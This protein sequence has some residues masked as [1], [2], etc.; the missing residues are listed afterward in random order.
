MSVCVCVCLCVRGCICLCVPV[1]V[2]LCVC[3]CVLGCLSVCVSVRATVCVCLCVCACYGHWDKREG[4]GE[5][6]KEGRWGPEKH[7]SRQILYA[8]Y[9]YTNERNLRQSVDDIKG[10]GDGK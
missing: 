9:V 8:S 3:L 7:S 6:R 1:C 2:C 4:E 5:S 10:G